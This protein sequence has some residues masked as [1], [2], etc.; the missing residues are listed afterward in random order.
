[1]SEQLEKALHAATQ[2]RYKGKSMRLGGGGRFAKG[3]DALMDEG[4]S[5]ESAKAIMAAKGRKLYGVSR[6]TKWAAA[7]RER[8]KG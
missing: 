4:H 8:A 3:V 6:M 7:G 5:R 2:K 1:M